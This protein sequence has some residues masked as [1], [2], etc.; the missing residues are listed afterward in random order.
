MDAAKA[1]CTSMTE[2]AKKQEEENAEDL[3]DEGTELFDALSMACE[4][5]TAA[6]VFAQ[7]GGK[8]CSQALRA[9][10]DCV[11]TLPCP[12]GDEAKRCDELSEALK[13]ACGN[14]LFK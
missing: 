10:L 9:Q 7:V 13:E 3:V 1:A 12:P 4:N 6:V 14:D 8:K 11:S 5:S 2:C